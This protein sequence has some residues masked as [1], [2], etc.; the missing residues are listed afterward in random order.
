M[1]L[2][3]TTVQV[4]AA[5]DGA[6]TAFSFA[7]LFQANADLIVYL[8][9][10]TTK[11]RTLQTI[12]THYTVSGAG[13]TGGGTVTF[14]TAPASTKT[15]VILRDPAKTQ[16]LDLL[17]ND[18]MP[19]E[20][21]EKRLD[22]LTMLVQRQGHRLD[23]LAGDGRTGPIF[24]ATA[25]SPITVDKTHNGRFLV[26]DATAGAVTVNLPGIST[27]TVPWNV[28]VKKLDGGAS[29]ITINRNGTDTIDGATSLALSSQDKGVLLIPDTG[30]SPDKW[31]AI[32]FG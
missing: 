30:P 16:T 27:L 22:K 25:D 4:T 11:A 5:G 31:S 1:T 28:T 2:T 3:S 15:V 26:I 17:E 24:L 7:H 20:E 23:E 12:T 29:A 19:A 8:E 9:D 10:T 6:T 14:V 21:L 13:A 32:K 18:A